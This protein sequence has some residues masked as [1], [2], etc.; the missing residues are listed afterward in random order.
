MVLE[1]FSKGLRAVIEGIA[2]H[3]CILTVDERGGFFCSERLA[4]NDFCWRVSV[5]ISREEGF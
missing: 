1:R 2:D 5:D 4:S 3:D